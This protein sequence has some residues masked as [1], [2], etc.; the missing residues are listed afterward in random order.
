ML[1]CPV[2]FTHQHG[3]THTDTGN[4]QDDNVHDRTGRAFRGQGLLP[5]ETARYDGVHCIVREL[6]QIAQYKRN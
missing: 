5:N 4:A 6:E 1:P 2:E 3:S